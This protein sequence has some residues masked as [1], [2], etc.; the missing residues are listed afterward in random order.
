MDKG[1]IRGLHIQS[2]TSDRLRVPAGSGL[3]AQAT[4]RQAHT[5]GSGYIDTPLVQHMAEADLVWIPGILST[6][7]MHCPR[8]AVWWAGGWN[9]GGVMVE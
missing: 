2:A 7:Q 1:A 5:G 3:R 6:Q 8:N 4:A 9:G